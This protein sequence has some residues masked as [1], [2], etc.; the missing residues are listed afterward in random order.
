MY[1]PFREFEFGRSKEHCGTA[2]QLG[3]P[4]M[5]SPL[6]SSS[7]ANESNIASDT[8]LKKPKPVLAGGVKLENV[9]PAGICSA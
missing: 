3:Q 7:S 2:I 6:V 9:A 1:L 5:P 4:D 8:A